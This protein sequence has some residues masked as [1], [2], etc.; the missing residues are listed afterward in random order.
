MVNKYRSKCTELVKHDHRM[1][2]AEAR[3]APHPDSVSL[4]IIVNFH[5]LG[6]EHTRL[7]ALAGQSNYVD[8]SLLGV[9]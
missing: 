2:L 6:M 5:H 8:S 4:A 1:H 3:L 7:L 9:A